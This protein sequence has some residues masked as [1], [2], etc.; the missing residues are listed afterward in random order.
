MPEAVRRTVKISAAGQVLVAVML[1]A[2]CSSSTQQAAG[3]STGASPTTAATAPPTVASGSVPASASPP[4][5]PATTLPYSPQISTAA[6]TSNGSQP[7][8]VVFTVSGQ[9]TSTAMTAMVQVVKERVAHIA[10]KP[11]TVEVSGGQI[12]LNGTAAQV[13]AM[14]AAGTAVS[15]TFRP[16]LASDPATGQAAAGSDPAIPAEAQSDFQA[17]NCASAPFIA[18]AAP[19]AISLGCSSDH[20]SKY[21]LGPSGVA[22]TDLSG[23]RAVDG[24]AG[25]QV[26]VTFNSRGSQ[27]LTSLTAAL[28]QNG[29]QVAVVWDGTVAS[30]ATVQSVVT[31]GALQIS[32]L[33]GQDQARALADILNLGALPVHLQTSSVTVLTSGG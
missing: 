18:A 24:S 9:P 31:G 7:A 2:G 26:D 33:T 23:A 4:S 14:K 22:G 6:T 10:G 32:G 21:L 13:E 20:K 8:Q 1:A 19:T 12:T 15:V 17:L 27:E 11:V 5:S 16:V 30:A 25:W 28:A 3:S 29:Q